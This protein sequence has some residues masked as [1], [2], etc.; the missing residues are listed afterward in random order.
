MTI[1]YSYQV[2]RV[3]LGKY[4]QDVFQSGLEEIS[5]LFLGDKL[6][7]GRSQRV[8]G[9]VE[10]FH[11]ESPEATCKVSASIRLPVLCSVF[12]FFLYRCQ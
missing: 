11:R 3:A 1:D 6:E 7:E 12:P 9:I 8:R 2:S 4:G 10:E 5:E